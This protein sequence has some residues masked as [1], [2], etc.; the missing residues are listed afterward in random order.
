MFSPTTY[1]FV[2]K[3]EKET[4]KMNFKRKEAGW[5]D[6]AS[7]FLFCSISLFIDALFLVLPIQLRSW[8]SQPSV[9]NNTDS[10]RY[11][12]DE[13]KRFIST[14]S[15]IN[16]SISLDQYFIPNAWQSFFSGLPVPP[17]L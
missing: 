2:E 6:R 12:L 10:Q 8:I 16:R 17:L 4:Q 3:E 1:F 14:Y 5:D 9:I 7:L 13:N 15:Y 11:I